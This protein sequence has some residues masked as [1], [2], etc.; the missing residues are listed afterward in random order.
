MGVM[1]WRL[2]DAARAACVAWAVVT[3]SPADAQERS[4]LSQ[5]DLGRLLYQLDV[6]GRRLVEDLG[7]EFARSGRWNPI[8]VDRELWNEA[9]AFAD[10]AARL[11][12]EYTTG[13]YP[14]MDRDARAVMLRGREVE[15]LID[16]ARVGNELRGDW[17]R[18]RMPLVR[19]ADSYGW[20]FDRGRFEADVVGREAPREDPD[21]P[22]YPSRDPWDATRR[23]AESILGVGYG[24]ADYRAV[25]DALRVVDR[26]APTLRSRLHHAPADP[27]AS[28]SW[29]RLGD[30]VLRDIGR[31]AGIL[32]PRTAWREAVE[33]DL[34]ELGSAA[35]DALRE[36]EGQRS[37][38]AVERNA[39]HLLVLGERI[40]DA[41]R[42]HQTPAEVGELWVE[43]RGELNR[44]AEVYRLR[45]IRTSRGSVGDPRGGGG[46]AAN[47]ASGA[48]LEGNTA[49]GAPIV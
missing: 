24:L 44:L 11:R 32:D 36:L 14:G 9:R 16:V 2:M 43:I 38:A 7:D 4:S 31:Q 19:L 15:R 8:G 5:A 39:R 49:R 18:L 30:A 40:D 23:T 12:R 33:R 37:A 42:T 20:D 27:S 17:E 13:P 26:A 41:L 22:D 29:E 10:G 46:S 47:V 45:P 28:G 1:R 35:G 3:A 48:H 21:R 34:V 6:D 25:S